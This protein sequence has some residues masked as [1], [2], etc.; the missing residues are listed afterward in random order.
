[1]QLLDLPITRAVVPAPT[2]IPLRPECAFEIAPLSPLLRL[3]ATQERA[4][5]P[6]S[7]FLLD[8]LEIGGSAPVS[9]RDSPAV[10]C[11]SRVYFD[12]NALP[13]PCL[14]G[15]GGISLSGDNHI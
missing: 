15:L 10:A 8:G 9:A 3:K 2:D 12:R 13:R 1:M 14:V 6:K 7:T 4:H 11:D 5:S